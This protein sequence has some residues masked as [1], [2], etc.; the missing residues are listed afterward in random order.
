M[1]NFL[2]LTLVVFVASLLLA[3]ISIAVAVWLGLLPGV[4]VRH[5]KTVLRQ[6]TLI[7]Y[8]IS[9]QEDQKLLHPEIKLSSTDLGSTYETVLDVIH[10]A[11]RD[12]SPAIP[13]PAVTKHP[14]AP[15]LRVE[16][17]ATGELFRKPL[18]TTS[19]GLTYQPR[20]EAELAA[21]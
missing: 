14:L 21:A 17:I 10:A 15:R 3:W 8:V 19:S 12:T 6:S 13:V 16:I 18:S 20:K 9:P 1:A 2:I 7:S 11:G 5:R 4:Q